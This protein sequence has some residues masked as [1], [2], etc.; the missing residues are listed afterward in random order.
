M[1]P[2]SLTSLNQKNLR[3]ELVLLPVLTLADVSNDACV[4]AGE[5]VEHN[6]G[7]IKGRTRPFDEIGV[8]TAPNSVNAGIGNHMY[9]G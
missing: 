8:K 2:G 4:D 9:L 7:A 1:L 6:Q 3:R 5:P